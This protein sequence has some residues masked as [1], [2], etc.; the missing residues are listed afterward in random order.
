MPIGITKIIAASFMSYL[1]KSIE[2]KGLLKLPTF[3]YKFRV[4][5]PFKKLFKA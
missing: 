2:K 3:Y 1:S 5:N 4:N